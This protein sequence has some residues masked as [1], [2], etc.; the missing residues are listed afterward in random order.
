MNEYR[1]RSQLVEDEYTHRYLKLEIFCSFL[2]VEKKNI[3]IQKLVLGESQWKWKKLKDISIDADH[4]EYASIFINDELLIMG[5]RIGS[6]N[7]IN[8]VRTWIYWRYRLDANL[9]AVFLS[10]VKSYNLN[11]SDR[12][13]WP[14]MLNNRGFFMPIFY[15]QKIYVFGGYSGKCCFDACEW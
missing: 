10:Q 7:Y 3:S 15:E 4:S 1:R 2:D 9:L 5:G 8:K 14:N 11:N 6:S 13:T 12:K